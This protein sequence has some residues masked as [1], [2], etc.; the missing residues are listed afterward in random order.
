MNFSKTSTATME[1]LRVSNRNSFRS[2]TR[3]IRLVSTSLILINAS[4][5]GTSLHP[6]TSSHV[7]LLMC[8]A[9][10]FHNCTPAMP[11]LN[12]MI[13]VHS[14]PNALLRCP[15]DGDLD[16]A[17]LAEQ[18]PQ[19]YWQTS[20]RMNTVPGPRL[21]LPNLTASA[22][23]KKP[24]KQGQSRPNQRGLRP[25]SSER[26]AANVQQSR[27]LRRILGRSCVSRTV[28]HY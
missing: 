20:S 14:I 1:S 28:I 27:R 18:Q 9:H 21:S 4:I 19:G 26:E 13:M 5:Q 17:L 7:T 16:R 22:A 23:A 8:Q 11:I 10:Q 6:T 25:P 3:D 2:R 24:S 12:S 15:A